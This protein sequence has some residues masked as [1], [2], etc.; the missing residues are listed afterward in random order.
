ERMGTT[1]KNLN[2]RKARPRTTESSSGRARARLTRDRSC[3]VVPVFGRTG[4][5]LAKKL[6]PSPSLVVIVCQDWL[7]D[8]SLAG[9]CLGP[10]VCCSLCIGVGLRQRFRDKASEFIDGCFNITDFPFELGGAALFGMVCFFLP[11]L[12]MILLGLEC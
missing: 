2:Y 6:R 5:A 11:V 8:A 1:V 12:F 4:R 3:S 10:R 9:R 7:F